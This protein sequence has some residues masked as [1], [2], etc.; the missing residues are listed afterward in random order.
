MA[1][2]VALASNGWILCKYILPGNQVG[3]LDASHT[4]RAF[5][6]RRADCACFARASGVRAAARP[7]RAAF[8]RFSVAVGTAQL[9]QCLLWLSLVVFPQFRQRFSACGTALPFR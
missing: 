6:W 4:D 9:A 8:A 2:F 3:C 5:D 1:E 7:S